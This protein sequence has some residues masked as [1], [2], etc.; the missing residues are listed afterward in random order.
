M[1]LSKPGT[2][3]G[4]FREEFIIN[5]D[6]NEDASGPLVSHTCGLAVGFLGPFAPVFGIIKSHRRL[7]R[8]NR[9]TEQPDRTAGAPGLNEAERKS[10]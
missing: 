8:I 10:A 7:L 3:L 6:P 5:C 4:L 2:L 9:T 1:A